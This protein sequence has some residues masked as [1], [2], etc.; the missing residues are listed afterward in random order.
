MHK[1][2]FFICPQNEILNLAGPLSAFRLANL[3]GKKPTYELSVISEMG[4]SVVGSSGLSVETASFRRNRPDTVI[5]I[6]G[7]LEPM[8]S[9]TAIDAAKALAAR[10]NRI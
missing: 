6:G 2:S 8:Q 4:G 3:L 5:F 10:A 7:E 9:P 1:V